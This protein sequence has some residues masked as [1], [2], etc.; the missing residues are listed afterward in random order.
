MASSDRKIWANKDGVWSQSS[1]SFNIG[2]TWV[3]PIAAYGKVNGGWKQFWPPTG[4]ALFTADGTWTVPTGITRVNAIVMGAGAGGGSGRRSTSANGGGGGGGGGAIAKQENLVVVP[5]TTCRITIGQG[6][7]GAVANSGRAGSNGGNSIFVLPSGQTVNGWGGGGGGGVDQPP[8]Q[9]PGGGGGGGAASTSTGIQQGGAGAAPGGR[10]WSNGSWDL[11]GGGGGSNYDGAPDISYDISK[12]NDGRWSPFLNTYG[13]WNPSTYTPTFDQSFN[14]YFAETGNYLIE[15]SVD[16]Y[17]QV[18]IGGALALDQTD[19]GGYRTSITST[20]YVNTGWHI[21]RLACTNTGGP[22]GVGVKINSPSGQE[23]FNTV[24]LPRAH[25]GGH[26]DGI[27]GYGGD[28]S[29]VNYLDKDRI[30]GSVVIC[31]GG[32]GGYHV[33]R[34]A[35]AAQ[36]S[37]RNGGAGGGGLP[38]QDATGVGSGGGGNAGADGPTGSGYRGQVYLYW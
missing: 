30:L 24:N 7:R 20:F 5:G 14:V 38:G 29:Q 25:A 35:T 8:P 22:G 26:A 36:V 9:T 31:G 19:S 27:N 28:G 34:G 6:G 10:G 17:G 32:A 3:N 1:S 18:L 21:V 12:V 37:S 13:I 33:D 23:M 15:A 4:A 16:N 11:G 2:G